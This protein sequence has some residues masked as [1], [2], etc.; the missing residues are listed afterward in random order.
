MLW[1]KMR[2]SQKISISLDIRFYFFR[3][4]RLFEDP[5][6][7]VFTCFVD[8]RPSACIMAMNSAEIKACPQRFEDVRNPVIDNPVLIDIGALIRTKL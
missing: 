7:D 8:R 4:A 3:D 2:S 6:V 1:L 5:F